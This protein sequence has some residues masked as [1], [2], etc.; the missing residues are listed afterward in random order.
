MLKGIREIQRR[1]ASGNEQQRLEALAETLQY[2]QQGFDFLMEY[3]LRRDTSEKLK[4]SAYWVLHGYN[5]YLMG[6]SE[7]GVIANSRLSA[8]DFTKLSRPGVMSKLAFNTKP[9]KSFSRVGAVTQKVGVSSR[10]QLQAFLL[11]FTNLYIV[12]VIIADLL[13]QS[14]K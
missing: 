6:S 3:S 2:G 11:Y 14:R 7:K 1:L 12:S 8:D 9:R 4:Q 10:M 13:T 5:P